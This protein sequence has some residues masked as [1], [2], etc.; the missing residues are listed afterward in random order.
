MKLLSVKQARSIWIVNLNDLNP[1]GLNLLGLIP[2]I[3]KKYNFQVFPTKPEELFGKEIIEIKF[4]GGGFQ[5]DPKYNISVDLTI[6]GWGFV[7]ETRSSTNDSNA[8]LNDL[9]NWVSIEVGLVPYQEVL[10][11]IVYLSE[12]LVQTDK[13][14]NSLNP[15]LE[16]FLKRLTSLVEG[17]EHHPFT[18]ETSSIIFG[19]DFTVVNPPGTFRFERLINVPFSESRYYSAAPLQTEIHFEMLEELESILSN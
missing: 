3:I 19:T 6:F 13:S 5:K 1:R 18:F 2:L 17:H 12:L 11:S 9:L 8:F 4:S 10:S 14:L 16:N 7:A 15:K